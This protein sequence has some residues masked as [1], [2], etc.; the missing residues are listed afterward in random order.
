MSPA[1]QTGNSAYVFVTVSD[2][3]D[4]EEICYN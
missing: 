2:N 1:M 4:F 3:S